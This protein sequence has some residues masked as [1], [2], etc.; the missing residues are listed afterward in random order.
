[1]VSFFS[2]FANGLTVALGAPKLNG[3]VVVAGLWANSADPLGVGVGVVK[4]KLRVGFAGALAL[5]LS[6]ISLAG[7]SSIVTSCTVFGGVT[8]RAGLAVPNAKDLLETSAAV[9]P[10]GA[11][12]KENGEVA[13][14]GA[15]EALEVPKAKPVVDVFSP[16]VAVAK[17]KGL[18][19]GFSSA[20][21]VLGRCPNENGA[22]DGAVPNRALGA[23]AGGAVTEAGAD[24]DVG[25]GAG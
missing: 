12:P 14:R 23:S 21:A 7:L 5:P 9:V 2:S 25:A 13:V 15:V 19:E 4:A 8:G 10:L 18:A 24:V 16:A 3:A 11:A 6:T 17:E 22:A 20:G 1:M